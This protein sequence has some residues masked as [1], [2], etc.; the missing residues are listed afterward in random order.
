MARPRYAASTSALVFG[1]KHSTFSRR[2]LVAMTEPLR[3]QA[4]SPAPPTPPKNSDTPYRASEPSI[5]TTTSSSL[6]VPEKV[7]GDLLGRKNLFVS[8]RVQ[9]NQEVAVLAVESHRKARAG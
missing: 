7:G 3:T 1:T 4:V 8:G 9:V 6:T 2:P 5:S